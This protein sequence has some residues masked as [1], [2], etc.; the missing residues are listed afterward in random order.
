MTLADLCDVAYAIQVDQK[1]RIEAACIAAGAE[2]E[3]GAA[4][5]EFDEWL[6]SE[7]EVIDNDRAQLLA[8][9]GVGRR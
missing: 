1:E 4:V 6:E 7:P 5:E 8:A 2:V 3:L 9:L